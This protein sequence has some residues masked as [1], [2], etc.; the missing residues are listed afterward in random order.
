MRH[1][2]QARRDMINTGLC[3]PSW[4]LQRARLRFAGASAGRAMP[5]ATV[6]RTRFARQ[7]CNVGP[8]P[9]L[10]SF[11]CSEVAL[12]LGCLSGYS[13]VRTAADSPPLLCLELLRSG[14]FSPASSCCDWAAPATV[15]HVPGPRSRLPRAQSMR[16][17]QSE[18]VPAIAS[19]C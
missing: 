7:F 17:S 3:V 5:R 12:F 18:C 14:A 4:V 9:Y 13:V 6:V 15:H 10:C 11:T 19:G 16:I 2:P 8:L 1:G